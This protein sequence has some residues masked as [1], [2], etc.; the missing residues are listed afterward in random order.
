MRAGEA[1]VGRERWYL[2]ASAAAAVVV[3][4]VSVAIA[5]MPAATIGDP[6][7]LPAPASPGREVTLVVPEGASV[8]DIARELER[9][10]VI[11]SAEQFTTLAALMGLGH[12]LAPGTYTLRTGSSPLTVLDAIRVKPSPP[13]IRLTFPEGLRI[14]EMAA[15]VEESGFATAAEFLQAVERAQ[16]PPGLAEYLPPADQLPPGQRLQGYLFPDTYLLPKGATVDDLVALMI[17]TLDERFTP[18]LRAAAAAKGLNPHQ[19]LT[20]ASIVEREAVIPAERPLIAGVFLN[21]LRAN[22]LLGADPT[23]QFAVALDPAN[24][25]RWGWWKRELTIDD[26][27]IQ[28]PYNTRL[29][30]GLP[31]GP[32]ANPGLASIEAVANAVETDYYYFV[33]NAKAGDGSHVFAVTEAEHERNKILYGAP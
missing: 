29:V 25:A 19:A 24:V 28:S 30:P 6:P 21:R 17:T 26:L 27:E 23:V 15:I 33:A 16:L 20:L 2:A 3:V 10:E 31:P 4:A 11:H 9:L 8:D 7:S 12:R 5:K 22:D 18:E 13:V 14:E 1:P 32:I